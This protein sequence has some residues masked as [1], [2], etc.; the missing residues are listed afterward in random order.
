MTIAEQILRAKSDYDEV[1]EAG[2]E[3]GKAEGGGEEIFYT[4]HGSMYKRHT[5]IDT[6]AQDGF[7]N[8]AYRYATEMETLSVPNLI[9]MWSSASAV[10]DSC[11]KL[12]SVYMPNI[13]QIGQNFF[14]NC[15]LLE[16]ITLGTT[17]NPMQKVAVNSFFNCP[18]LKHFNYIGVLPVTISFEKSINLNATSIETIINSLSET[19][20]GQSLTLS[21][22]AV[23]KAF[24]EDDWSILVNSKTN[25]TISLV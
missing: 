2:Y 20:E 17:S 19:A 16:D 8:Y 23:N 13:L 9:A 1:Y 7:Y 6:N 22:E 14:S 21:G 15:L 11:S 3:K 4:N 12:R 24:A 10:F 18:S 5:I 25:W